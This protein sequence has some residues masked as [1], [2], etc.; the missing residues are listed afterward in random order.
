MDIYCL[1]QKTLFD[2][3]VFETQYKILHN[4]VPTNHLL[5]QMGKIPSDSCNFCFLYSQNIFHLFFDCLNV[6]NFWYQV[7]DRV[8]VNQQNNYTILKFD[9]FF[10][11]QSKEE[12]INKVIMYGK[13]F[14]LQCKYNDQALCVNQFFQLVNDMVMIYNFNCKSQ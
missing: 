8:N 11:H 7:E 2:N 3:K 9:V 10:G 4:Y 6:R 12:Y 1:P 5:F 14:I 13:H